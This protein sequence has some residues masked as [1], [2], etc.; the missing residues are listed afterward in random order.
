MHDYGAVNYQFDLQATTHRTLGGHVYDEINHQADPLTMSRS[1]FAWS[2][3]LP[4]SISHVPLLGGTKVRTTWVGE[5]SKPMRFSSRVRSPAPN[6]ES[7]A[8]WASLMPA[9]DGRRGILISLVTFRRAG[10]VTLRV[11]TASSVVRV[12][13]RDCSLASNMRVTGNVGY[14]K[15]FSEFRPYL[16]RIAI[17]RHFPT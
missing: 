16:R 6:T 9:M 5:P 4:S 14:R 15:H 10:S 12:Q 7:S 1:L 3:G 8:P 11:S 17:H 13:V 2:L